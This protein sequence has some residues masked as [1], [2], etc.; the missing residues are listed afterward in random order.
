MCAWKCEKLWRK[1]GRG[2]FSGAVELKLILVTLLV[3]ISRASNHRAHDARPASD[4]LRCGYALS[5]ATAR[6]PANADSVRAQLERA[7]PFAAGHVSFPPLTNRDR[8]RQF[9]SRII[10]PYTSSRRRAGS[11]RRAHARSA[12][13]KPWAALRSWRRSSTRTRRPVA[14]CPR[15]VPTLCPRLSPF[16]FRPC[17]THETAQAARNT[18]RVC[19]GDRA[20]GSAPRFPQK[21]MWSPVEHA[22]SGHMVWDPFGTHRPELFTKARFAGARPHEQRA[23]DAALYRESGVIYRCSRQGATPNTR[24][25]GETKHAAPV[26]AFR[27]GGPERRAGA[28][29]RAGAATYF[30]YPRSDINA[31]AFSSPEHSI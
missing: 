31:L 29:V 11:Y 10:P 26:T 19:S 17:A 27:F 2:A 12:E 13:R 16:G 23:G 8:T 4:A 22:T 18:L 20:S 14:M 6:G 3:T 25:L 15:F 9:F 21:N 5:T 28:W 1:Y 24:A 30:R 7:I